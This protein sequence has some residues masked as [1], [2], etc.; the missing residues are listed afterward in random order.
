VWRRG[1]TPRAP[2]VRRHRQGRPNG[3]YV[4]IS[5]GG[6][7]PSLPLFGGPQSW[8]SCSSLPT[9]GESRPVPP[10]QAQPRRQIDDAVRRS[11]E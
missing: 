2:G 5:R 7:H 11:G 8:P 6:Q 9:L 4:V 10:R 3:S 1:R